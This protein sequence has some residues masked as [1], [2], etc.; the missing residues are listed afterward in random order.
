[1]RGMRRAGSS[2]TTAGCCKGRPAVLRFPGHT[3]P[4][5]RQWSCR[6]WGKLKLG[7]LAGV[8]YGP[9]LKRG[10]PC[11]E[12]AGLASV[13]YPSAAY[14]CGPIRRGHVFKQL[15]LVDKDGPQLQMLRIV[16]CH[17]LEF[18]GATQ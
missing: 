13:D 5:S 4:R 18:S 6:A 16:P 11:R 10:Y 17:E 14:D 8:T 12:P 15:Q 9:S 7:W 1:M 2:S 3:N